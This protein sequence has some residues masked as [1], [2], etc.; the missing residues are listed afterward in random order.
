MLTK[1][2]VC[3]M[4]LGPKKAEYASEF[5]GRKYFF[6]NKYCLTDFVGGNKIA[7]F[8]MKIGVD[9]DIPTYWRELRIF[10]CSWVNMMKNSI[11]KEAYY[12][13]SHRMMQRYATDGFL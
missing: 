5:L 13:N 2:P 3:G 6:D 10:A 12:F 1:D 8:S 7:Y 11:C 4:S 9:S